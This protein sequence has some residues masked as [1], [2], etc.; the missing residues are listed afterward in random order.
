MFYNSIVNA[1]EEVRDSFLECLEEEI[2]KIIKEQSFADHMR[3]LLKQNASPL[4]IKNTPKVIKDEY[5]FAYSVIYQA[6]RVTALIHD[7]GHPPFSHVSEYALKDLREYVNKLTEK[8][9]RQREF[10]DIIQQHKS[11]KD[12]HEEIGLTITHRLLRSVAEQDGVDV[13]GEESAELKFFYFLVR[14]VVKKILEEPAQIFKDIHYLVDGPIDCDR[15]DYVSRDMENSGFNFGRIE[16]D[17]LINS[18]KLMKEKDKFYFCPDV[19]VLST[20]EDFFQRRWTL[21]KYLIFHHRAIKTD[22]LLKNVTFELSKLYLEKEDLKK[23][24]EHSN[25]IPLNI[26]DSG[27]ALEKHTKIQIILIL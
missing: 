26:S 11:K 19:R 6:I 12:L 15:L 21:Y 27:K 9:N 24:E 8:N 18:M 13:D 10:L 20:I 4:L 3:T 7:I 14:E 17:R 2:I 1:D 25:F 22:Y 23:E 5:L 16:Y